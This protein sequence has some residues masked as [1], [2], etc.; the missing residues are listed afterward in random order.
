MTSEQKEAQSRLIDNMTLN[1]LLT[2]LESKLGQIVRAGNPPNILEAINRVKRELQL[3][4]FESQKFNKSVAARNLIQTL[5]KRPLMPQKFCSFCKRNGHTINECRTR[6]NQQ[7]SSPNFMPNAYSNQAQY[8]RPNI[9]N[10]PIQNNQRQFSPQ[11]FQQSSGLQQNRPSV[12]RPNPNFQQRF[13]SNQQNSNFNRQ[14]PQRT[15]HVNFDHYYD[16]QNYEH[17]NFYSDNFNNQ[18]FDDIQN[19]QTNFNDQYLPQENYTDNSQDLQ[20]NYTD[21]WQNQYENNY[22]TNFQV[23]Q[24]TANPQ[25]FRVGPEYPQDTPTQEI[26]YQIDQVSH[27]IQNMNLN[28][29]LNF[30]DQTFM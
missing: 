7:F 3:S 13:S 15:H 1:T 6:Q 5:P 28:P 16:P 25:D 8:P 2:G 24:D 14:N 10:I 21:N 29:L 4:Y 19:Y 26:N 17:T 12:I 22:A 18:Q 11:N 20:G 23:I 30:P 27:Q 9:Q